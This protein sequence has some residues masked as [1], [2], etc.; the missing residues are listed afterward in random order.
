MKQRIKAA[1]EHLDPDEPAYFCI[2][3]NLI[4]LAAYLQPDAE[5]PMSDALDDDV[6]RVA[7][8]L[9]RVSHARGT[10]ITGHT[11][12]YDLSGHTAPWQEWARHGQYGWVYYIRRRSMVKIGVTEN[13]Y[14]RMQA[15]LPEEILAVEPGDGN[16]EAEMHKKFARQRVRGPHHEWF[17]LSPELQAHIQAVREKHGPPPEGLPTLSPV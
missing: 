2:I 7:F 17:Y 10:S 6:I 4:R 8:R 16:L 15:L 9:G 3:K 1:G 11:V 12:E 5:T 14:R 13:L